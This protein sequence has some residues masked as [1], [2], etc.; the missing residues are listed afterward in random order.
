MGWDDIIPENNF[1]WSLF[2]VWSYLQSSYKES[3]QKMI[4]FNFNQRRIQNPDEHLKL[5]FLRQRKT[6]VLESLFN[7]VAGFRP[8]S[9][10]KN[11]HSD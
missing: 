3:A 2:L 4:L 7:K 6:S 5:S 9:P 8:A 1:L 10:E 11:L